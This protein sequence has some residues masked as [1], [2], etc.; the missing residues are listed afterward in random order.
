MDAYTKVTMRATVSVFF[1]DTE[2][3]TMKIAKLL[4]NDYQG[5]SLSLS[6]ISTLIFSFV[7]P[8]DKVV[9][10]DLKH[11]RFRLAGD[12]VFIG[13]IDTPKLIGE[14]VGKERKDFAKIVT[15]QK[16]I[17]KADATIF[18]MWKT[19]FPTERE[20]FSVKIINEQ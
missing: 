4:F 2:S 20:K 9:L 11:I 17:K 3:L 16:N 8:V 10:S 15:T 14:L 12:P 13:N 18:P 6:N 7:E 19:V 1:F 5:E